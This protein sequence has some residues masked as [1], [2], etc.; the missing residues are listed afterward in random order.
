MIKFSA[1]LLATLIAASVN[2][3]TVDLRIMETTD[4]HSNMMDFDYYK[5][6][7]TEKFGLVRTASL[8][9]AARNEVKNS[10]LVDNGDLIQGSPLGDYM[11]A[12]GLKD[13]DIHPVYKAL[14]T[15]DYAVGN[16]G[17]HEFNYGLDYLHNALAGAKFPYVNANI[18]DVKTQ[19]PLF[20][21]YLIKET[22][23]IDKDGNPQTLKIGYI[24]FV[25]PQI[26]IWDKANLSGKVTVNDITETARKYVPEMRE[27]GA[28]I[29]VVIA[30]S[31]LSADPYHSMAENSVYYLSEVPGVDAIM[32]GHAHAV[33]PGKDFADIKGAD[34][35]K[36]TL[37]GIPA[38]MPGMWGDHLG[39][40]DL[41]LNN[42]SGKW[43]V[44]QAKAQARPI[45]DAA[46]KKSL[47]AED[48]KL[49]DILKA[50]HDATREFVSKPIG[51]SADNMY[52]YLALVQDD[53][54]VQVVNNAQKAYVEHFIQGDPDLAKL[55]VLSAAAPFKVGGRKNDP[56]SFVEVEK[57]QLTFRNA[58]DLYLYPNTLVVVKARGKEVKEWLECSAGQFN[59][60][61]IHSNKPQSLINWDGFRT[62]N[63]DVID[64][65]NY[66]IDVSQPARYDGECQMVNPQAE[67]IKNLTF[68]GKPVDP[69]ATFLV[70]TNNYRAYGGKFA[71]TGDSHIAFASPD[72]N[73]AVLAAW[74]G[75]ES[76]R[77][78]E[79]HPAADNNWRL[80]PIHSD[81]AL[82]IRFE[83]S[84]GDKAAAFIKAKGQYPMKKVAVDDIGFA[85]YQVDLNK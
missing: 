33:F 10:V 29:V 53:P 45:Y 70:A 39:V 44:T 65:V 35:A 48:S 66:Q 30:H 50:D 59:Q 81:T 49:V 43:Q 67:R 28:D 6:T 52:S 79:I 22:S 7:A 26:M 27:K 85:I 72:E 1:T 57:G 83:T 4:L 8:I 20:T 75:A 69:N 78:G 34:I 68:N 73:R 13:G 31:G 47:A 17:N 15:L 24:G 36:G 41:V 76:K 19:K 32:F 62:Y 16:L 63:F 23:V 40:V 74:I 71:G 37:N 18:I 12:K 25:P 9:H 82:D 5:D 2:A 46:A 51:K 64:G 11:A 84:P 21:P 38:V 55:P 3:A 61:D 54:T 58:A 42:D 14:N 56:A 77:A 60:I 80:A